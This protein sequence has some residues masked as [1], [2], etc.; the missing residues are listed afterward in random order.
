MEPIYT[1]TLVGW[2][3][4]QLVYSFDRL[5]VCVVLSSLILVKIYKDNSDLLQ[6]SIKVLCTLPA[7][8]GAMS[9]HAC[10]SRY[11]DRHDVTALLPGL[12]IGQGAF[13]GSRLR[14]SSS[15]GM[16]SFRLSRSQ[17]SFGHQQKKRRTNAGTSHRNR[18]PME[19]SWPLRD[20]NGT[21]THL[22]QQRRPRTRKPC[23]KCR[24]AK[25][26]EAASSR[27]LG[28][29][30]WAADRKR[31]VIGKRGRDGHQRGPMCSRR[32]SSPNLPVITG[33]DP[34]LLLADRRDETLRVSKRTSNGNR[35]ADLVE[36]LD[37]R[38]WGL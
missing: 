37:R 32:F 23:A 18:R 4:C 7:F 19:R 13:G 16:E 17:I 3:I 9:G 15:Q 5:S 34:H 21:L 1:P 25:C 31:S 11:R 36:P 27:L 24:S 26:L 30:G 8:V 29:L 14:T 6:Q 35:Q 22:F 10:Q 2:P 33:L 38:S 28:H 12:S 20:N